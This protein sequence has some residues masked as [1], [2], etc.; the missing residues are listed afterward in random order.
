MSQSGINTRPSADG[1]VHLVMV[2]DSPSLLDTYKWM[3]SEM[4]GM[5]PALFGG[6]DAALA[7][8]QSLP[9]GSRILLVSDGDLGVRGKN[10]PDL[11]AVIR[12][13]AEQ[14]GLVV[15][16]RLFS[17]DVG[18]YQRDPRVAFLSPEDLWPKGEGLGWIEQLKNGLQELRAAQAPL[19]HT[20]PHSTPLSIAPSAEG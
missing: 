12:T 17:G 3:V 9:S 14:K 11:L 18:A 4:L 8:C 1:R 10:G 15:S 5:I 16:L 2:D 13:L 7:Y 19:V 6:Y 20:K